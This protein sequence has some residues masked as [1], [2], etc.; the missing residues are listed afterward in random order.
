MDLAACAKRVFIAMEH[1][2]PRDGSP[3]LLKQCKLPITAPGVVKM[4]STD[5]GFFEVTPEGFVLRE[6]AP[7][8]TPEEIQELTEAKLIVPDEVPEVRLRD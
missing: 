4:V 1:C 6:R 2:N 5:L 8:W 7:G 3:R